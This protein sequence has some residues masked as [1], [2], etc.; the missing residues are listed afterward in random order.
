MSTQATGQGLLL[1]FTIFPE[2][3][4]STSASERPRCRLV[5]ERA[6]PRHDS[7]VFPNGGIE[8]PKTFDDLRK[9]VEQLRR[10]RNLSRQLRH[11]QTEFVRKALTPPV[12]LVNDG[13]RYQ[14]PLVK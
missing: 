7:S 11:F 12:A 10:E 6:E 8:Y 9:E 4:R 14:L 1:N 5:I 3:H 2:R 13:D